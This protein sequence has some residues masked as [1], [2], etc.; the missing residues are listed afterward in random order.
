M[1]IDT[2]KKL[3]AAFEE[4]HKCKTVYS[5]KLKTNRKTQL[6]V[7]KRLK[8]LREE[9]EDIRSVKEKIDDCIASYP[10]N[11]SND[12]GGSVL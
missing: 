7:I 11:T 2:R 6:G 3:S 12:D 8:T 10:V 5:E 4:V 1:S 9:E